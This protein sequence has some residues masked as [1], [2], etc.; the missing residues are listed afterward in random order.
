MNDSGDFHLVVRA[1]SGDRR[2]FDQLTLKYRPRVITLAAR[3]TGNYADAEDVAQEAFTK[4]YRGLC[5]FRRECTFYTWLFRIAVNSAKNVLIARVGN[6]VATT[7]AWPDEDDAAVLPVSLQEMH[8][9]EKLALTDEMRGAVN[10]TL[11]QLP[12]A[13]RA[14]IILREIDGLTYAQIAAAMATPVGT[15]RSRIFRARELIDQHLRTVFEGG[16]G[17]A[18]QGEASTR[19]TPREERRAAATPARASENALRC[20]SECRCYTRGLRGIG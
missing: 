2:A 11:E 13:H 16:L 18:M 3:Y 5:T 1:Q 7:S 12:E 10:A 9:P 14:A 20:A 19:L 6:S 8:T 17:R 4:A 15:V